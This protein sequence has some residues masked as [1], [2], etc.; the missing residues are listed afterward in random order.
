MSIVEPP[1]RPPAPV[2]VHGVTW[3]TYRK[4]R[5]EPANLHLR[6]TFDQGRLELM[7]PS[8]MHERVAYLLGRMVDA[9]TEEH[10]IALQGCG[11][12]TFQ[13]EDLSRGLEPDNCFYIQNEPLVRGRD[14][15]DLTRDPPPDLVIEVDITSPSRRRLPMYQALGVPE[16]WVWRSDA[17]TVHLLSPSGSYEA[18]NASAV[19]PGFPLSTAT[20]FLDLRAAMSDTELIR[21]FRETIR[22]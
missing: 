6:M 7:S 18:R 15:L 1:V 11:T 5:D 14:D 21:R 4:L 10:D 8:K 22:R 17:L 12:V 16:V 2:V 3:K 13:R 9:W 20:E 19:F